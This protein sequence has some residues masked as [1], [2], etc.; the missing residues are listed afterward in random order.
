MTL[1]G[2][3][4][5]DCTTRDTTVHASWGAEEEAAGAGAGGS[6]KRAADEAPA[7]EATAQRRKTEEAAGAEGEEADLS[8]EQVAALLAEKKRALLARLG[9]A[10]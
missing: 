6:G 4:A 1:S 5:R 9:A 8:P 3:W 10:E 7:D 2:E